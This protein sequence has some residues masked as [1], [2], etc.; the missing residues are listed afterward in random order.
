MTVDPEWIGIPH[1]YDLSEAETITEELR[2][3]KLAKEYIIT[4]V[5]AIISSHCGPGTF[6]IAYLKNR[7]DLLYALLSYKNS[8]GG[9]KYVN[10]KIVTDSTAH[11]S[12]ELLKRFSIEVIP[13]SVYFGDQSLFGWCRPKP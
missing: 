6:C 7:N 9:V 13:L 12:P 11:F 2:S 1:C 10:K 5:G 4:Q 8:F 3:L